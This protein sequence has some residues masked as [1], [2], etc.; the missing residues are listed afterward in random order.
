[1]ADK[2]SERYITYYNLQRSI[3][4]CAGITSVGI[5]SLNP[6]CRFPMFGVCA[7]FLIAFILIHKYRAVELPFNLRDAPRSPD[8]LVWSFSLTTCV[9]AAAMLF[10]FVMGEIVLGLLASIIGDLILL[11]EV[12]NGKRVIR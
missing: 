6:W 9:L 1:M 10:L 12:Q 5:L 3:K 2:H 11:I 8:Y 4:Q 7:L